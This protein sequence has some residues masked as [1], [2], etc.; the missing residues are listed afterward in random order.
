[1]TRYRLDTNVLIRFLTHDDPQQ[2]TQADALFRDAEEGRCVLV[3]D[4]IVLVEAVWVLA[5][6]YNRPRKE[7][8]ESLARLVVMPGIRC[9]EARVTLDALSRYQQ[10]DLDIVDCFLAA[11]SAAEGDAVATFDRGFRCW[12]DVLLWDGGKAA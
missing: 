4:S 1:M 12:A 7:I 8:S 5:T 3:L 6:V 10:S 11:Q 9:K 2:A